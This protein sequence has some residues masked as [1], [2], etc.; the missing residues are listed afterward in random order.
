MK[1]L[2]LGKSTAI[3]GT[4]ILMTLGSTACATKKYV[5]QTVS[6]VEA[7]TSGL[8]KKSSDHASAIGEI[9][10]NVS[11]TDEKATEA[12]RNAQ[13]AGQAAERANQAALEARN[14]ADAAATASE[15][16]ATRIG[17]VSGQLGNID[18]YQLVTTEA[19]L[20][21]LNKATL[22]K[23]AKAQLDQA[24]ANIQN[25]K[26]FVLEIEG[27]TDK[28][29]NRDM[30]VALGERRADAVVRYLTVQHQVPLR[31]IHVLGVGPENYAADNKTRA[32]RKQNRRV[33]LKVYALDLSGKQTAQTNMSTTGTDNQMRSRT[34]PDA[35]TGRITQSQQTDTTARPTTETSRP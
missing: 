13:A 1:A 15:Q 33:E 31:K 8:E 26:N 9:E 5:R 34:A 28:S 21:P 22:T 20:F 17:E 18:N 16:N 7:R 19:I 35:T 30:N 25:N 10:N 6:P 11:R 3:F 27:F 2:T 14:R 23:D 12:N 24:V 32:G 4:A 29:G